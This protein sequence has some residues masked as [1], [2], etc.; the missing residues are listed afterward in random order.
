MKSPAQLTEEQ[1]GLRREGL[2]ILARIIARHYLEHPQRYESGGE[3]AV[4]RRAERCPGSATIPLAKPS[5]RE[6]E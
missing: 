6:D 3:R 5:D 4:G 1:E 2:R